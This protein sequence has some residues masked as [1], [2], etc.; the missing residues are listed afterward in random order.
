MANVRISFS[1]P[2]DLSKDPVLE[3]SHEAVTT[4]SKDFI[5]WEIKSTDD[6]VKKVKIVAEDMVIDAQNTVKAKNLFPNL[7]PPTAV[8][9]EVAYVATGKH[10]KGYALAWGLA[11]EV[12]NLKNGRS[13][14]KY[15]VYGFDGNGKQIAERDPVIITDPPPIPGVEVPD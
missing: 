7:I 4:W 5:V 15:G 2:D 8:E 6:R 9:K 3:I 13:V 11:P 1:Q 12:P 10:A 14:D